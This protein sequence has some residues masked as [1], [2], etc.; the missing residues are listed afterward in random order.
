[1]KP[2]K[3]DR[4]GLRDKMLALFTPGVWMKK[5]QIAE[6][7]KVPPDTITWHLGAAIKDKELIATG[8]TSTRAFALPDTPAP[9]FGTK[10]AKAETKAAKPK[11]KARKPE[12]Q[13]TVHVNVPRGHILTTIEDLVARRELIDAALAALRQL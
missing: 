4:A 8:S 10:P 1:M 9:K 7:L 13:A 2:S 6:A 5:A 3:E 11:T 12:T